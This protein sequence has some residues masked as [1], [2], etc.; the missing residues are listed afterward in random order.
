VGPSK[1]SGVVGIVTVVGIVVGELAGVFRLG[2]KTVVGT[3]TVEEEVV[4]GKGAV[5]GGVTA[6]LEGGDPRSGL[7]LTAGS[8]GTVRRTSAPR[9]TELPPRCAARNTMTTTATTATVTRPIHRR[10]VGLPSISESSTSLRHHSAPPGASKSQ[11]CHRFSGCPRT[12]DR[13][14]RGWI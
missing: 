2:E 12:P 1:G 10:S 3:L 6:P 4:D 7:R 14:R 5:E 9:L 8:T 13:C 11:I